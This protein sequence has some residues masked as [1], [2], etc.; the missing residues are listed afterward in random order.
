MGA[1]NYFD[2]FW[3]SIPILFIKIKICHKYFTKKAL[4]V[5]LNLWQALG[6]FT[7]WYTYYSF[8][9]NVSFR[10]FSI[11]TNKKH[12]FCK[13]SP[14]LS[15]LQT[16]FWLNSHQTSILG[17]SIFTRNYFEKYCKS[18]PLLAKN[19][20]IKFYTFTNKLRQRS[21]YSTVKQLIKYSGLKA[22]GSNFNDKTQEHVFYSDIYNN[23]NSCVLI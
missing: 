5:F 23:G 20:Y 11:K 18:T 6:F 14:L 17:K 4:T 15:K 13:L 22:L 16:I 8:P 10:W 2:N 7:S 12:R 3:K 21:I 1:I 9:N 19:P